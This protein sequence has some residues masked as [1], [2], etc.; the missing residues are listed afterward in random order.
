MVAGVLRVSVISQKGNVYTVIGFSLDA[1]QSYFLL[2][3][4]RDFVLNFFLPSESGCRLAWLMI[5]AF[6]VPGRNM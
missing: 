2:E 5:Q 1:T 6:N 4:N 3:A